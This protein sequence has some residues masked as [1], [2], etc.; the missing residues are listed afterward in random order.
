MIRNVADEWLDDPVSQNNGS[1]V[2]CGGNSWCC[3]PAAADGTCDCQSGKGTF[4]VPDGQAQTIISYSGLESTSTSF[5]PVSTPSKPLS[6]TAAIIAKPTPLVLSTLRATMVAE[7]SIMDSL[8]SILSTSITPATSFVPSSLLSKVTSTSQTP[9]ITNSAVSAF[10]VVPVA[11]STR[12]NA[13]ISTKHS[14]TFYA[15]PS[16]PGVSS[17]GSGESITAPTISEVSSTY[18]TNSAFTPSSTTSAVSAI[19]TSSVVAPASRNTALK[20]GLAIAI[21]VA[22][23]VGALIAVLI[24]RRR[25]QQYQN[26][27]LRNSRGSSQGLTS[28][29]HRNEAEDLYPRVS[30]PRSSQIGIASG[31]RPRRRSSPAALQDLND[32]TVTPPSLHSRQ[33][34][35]LA[36]IP[37]VT[38]FDSVAWEQALR[39]H[40]EESFRGRQEQRNPRIVPYEGT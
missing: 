34:S 7:T 40:R 39:E 1:L 4:T 30:F 38:P 8:S 19:S 18:T 13:I 32:P 5:Q 28:F 27:D 12:P 37:A 22:A 33:V 10:T 23:I 16:T 26:G 36:P 24:W 21:P 29:W 31:L 6:Q 20:I 2:Y 11:S 17:V 3:G 15:Q 35:G 9:G 25:R 14:S